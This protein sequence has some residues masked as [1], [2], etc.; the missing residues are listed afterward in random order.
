MSRH[1]AGEGWTVLPWAHLTIPLVSPHQ[2]HI[3]TFLHAFRMAAKLLWRWARS[4]LVLDMRLQGQTSTAQLHSCL[5]SVRVTTCSDVPSSVWP[6]ACGGWPTSTLE[7]HG[8]PW[9]MAHLPMLHSVTKSAGPR[10]IQT[11]LKNLRCSSPSSITREQDLQMQFRM[12]IV[13]RK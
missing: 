10:L 4:N 7:S 9:S 1:R 5:E 6:C 13:F 3:L 11:H 8:T 2:G 12:A